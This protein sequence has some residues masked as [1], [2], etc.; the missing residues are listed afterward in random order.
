MASFSSEFLKRPVVDTNGELF[1]LLEEIIID[2]K[3]GQLV[4]LL[5]DVSKE[6]DTS[7]L[8]WPMVD[9]LCRVP[10]QEVSRIADRIH[11]TR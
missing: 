10:A 6:I 7:K 9:G 4:E 8:P 5:V 2:T 11:L 3:S 1:G